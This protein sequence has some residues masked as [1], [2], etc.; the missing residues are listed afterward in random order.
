MVRPR[1]AEVTPELLNRLANEPAMLAQLGYDHL[2]LSGFFDRPDNVAL[3]DANG[4]AL[5]GHMGGG[6]YEG[7]YLFPRHCRGKD[8]LARARCFLDTIFTLHG[9]RLI[10]G[11]TP[12]ENLSA[13]IFSRALGFTRQG[14]SVENGRSCVLFHM[15]RD[16]WATLSAASSA[17]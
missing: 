8:A 15:E 1:P 16:Q 10:V 11:A 13:R 5:F 4:V 12:A 14:T 17:E 3:G 7:H 6:I 2:D 9:A